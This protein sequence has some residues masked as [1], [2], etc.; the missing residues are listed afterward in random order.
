MKSMSTS[1]SKP[2]ISLFMPKKKPEPIEHGTNFL[3][4]GYS[5]LAEKASEEGTKKG[6]IMQ[7]QWALWHFVL[8]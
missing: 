6:C 7:T 1:V 4:G 8:K 3:G 2:T 5:H